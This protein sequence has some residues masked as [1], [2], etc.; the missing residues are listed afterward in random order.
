[1]LELRNTRYVHLCVCS[2]QLT[3]FAVGCIGNGPWHA[4]P[5]MP[6]AALP[7][8]R[9]RGQT[10]PGTGNTHMCAVCMMLGVVA[11]VLGYVVACSGRSRGGVAN[12]VAVATTIAVAAAFSCFGLASA[13]GPVGHSVVADIAVSQLTPSA[14]AQLQ[15]LLGDKPLS[16]YA[17][18]PDGACVPAAGRG[19]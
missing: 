2:G 16:Y 19:G 15:A 7:P 6:L 4:P 5:C 12:A 10:A 18:L 3:R 9:G 17:P 11:R 1:M 8:L 14:R 13:W